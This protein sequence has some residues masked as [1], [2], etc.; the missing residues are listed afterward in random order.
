[1]SQ[2]EKEHCMDSVGYIY[3]CIVYKY[4]Y[5]CNNSR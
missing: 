2:L 4:I 5:A 1:M 3:E